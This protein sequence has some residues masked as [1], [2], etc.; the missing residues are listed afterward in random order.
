SRRPDVAKGKGRLRGSDRGVR[1]TRSPR[2]SRDR[3]EAY[4]GSWG[5]KF[6]ASRERVPLPDSLLLLL[7]RLDFSRSRETR[8]SYSEESSARRG[9]NPDVPVSQSIH[10]GKTKDNERER[11]LFRRALTLV[12]R[13][14]DPICILAPCSRFSLG[15]VVGVRLREFSREPRGSRSRA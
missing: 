7:P 14:R 11:T 9:P 4:P 8:S 15:F 5:C 6:V 12:P 2:G 3:E 1:G 10:A 13:N